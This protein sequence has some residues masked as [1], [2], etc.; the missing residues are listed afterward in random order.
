MRMTGLR[1]EYLERCKGQFLRSKVLASGGGGGGGGGS[2]RKRR[3][4][5]KRLTL[6]LR[7]DL[8]FRFIKIERGGLR[9]H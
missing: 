3:R 4:Q 5:R 6:H 2:S 8:W 9:F 1:C 7:T